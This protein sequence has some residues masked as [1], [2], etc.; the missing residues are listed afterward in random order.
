MILLLITAPAMGQTYSVTDSIPLG[1]SGAW[2]YLRADSESRRLYVSH[3]TEVVV[4]DLD[5]HKV[6]GR[7]TGFGFIHGIVIVKNLNTGFLSDGQKD[8][9]VT[10]DPATLQIKGRIATEA[11]PNSMAYNAAADRLF[12]GHKPSQSTT[13]IQA[14]TGQ[15]VKSI[16]LGG[17][18]E[19]PVSDASSVFVNIQSKNEIVRIDAKTLAITGHFP[20]APCEGPGGLAIDLDHHRLF[21]ACDNNLMAIVNSETGAV[22]TT[23]PIGSGPDAAAFDADRHLAFSSNGEGSLTVIAGGGDHYRVVQNVKTE[24]GARTMG[25]DAKT[26]TIFLSDAE[27]GPPPAPTA[28]NP[29]PPNH[30]TALPGTF[31]LLVVGPRL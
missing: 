27:L 1:G 16:P 12:V 31:K 15:I 10:F 22:V 25:L 3:S 21:A 19:F 6:V 7:M 2:D 23:L 18:P 9:V 11:N 26:H 30:P 29:Y 4:L 13:V 14:S 20:L 28:A 24:K 8:E 5:T 17:I